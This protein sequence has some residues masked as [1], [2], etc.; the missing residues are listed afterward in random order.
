MFHLYPV[1]QTIVL[2]L[3]FSVYINVYSRNRVIRI[4]HTELPF[5][6]SEACIPNGLSYLMLFCK[7]YFTHSD[8]LLLFTSKICI[9][10]M[11]KMVIHDVMQNKSNSN[12]LMWHCN[13]IFTESKYVFRIYTVVWLRSILLPSYTI[14]L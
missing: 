12:N 5:V 11:W 8:F 4:T 9:Y 2:L 7:L 6:Y 13:V 10:Y 1:S 14:V 3:F